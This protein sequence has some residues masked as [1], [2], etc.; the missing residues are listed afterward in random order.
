M[1]LKLASLLFGY[2]YELLKEQTMASRQ[3][4]STLA[5]LLLIPVF[6]WG[7]TGYFLSRNLMDSSF[8]VALA[9][10]ISMAGIIFLVDRSF[11]TASCNGTGKYLGW[12]RFGF[13]ILSAVLGAATLDMVIFEEDILNYQTKKSSQITKDKKDEYLKEHAH[14]LEPFR[15]ELDRQK[16]LERETHRAWM[17]EID[18]K[19]GPSGVGKRAA[20]KK[21]AWQ[22]AS[23]A[24]SEAT[25][26]L[27]SNTYELD[28]SAQDYGDAM[29]DLGKKTII[30]KFRDFHE[31]VFSDIYAGI[32][33]GLFFVM[34]LM[35]ELFLL[36][37]KTAARKTIFDQ[38]QELE[39]ELILKELESM[40]TMKQRMLFRNEAL[41]PGFQREVTRRASHN[42]RRA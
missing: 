5:L 21:L 27:D 17:D 7:I 39:E 25:T 18:G 10:S 9:V 14:M 34:M 26:K 1:T 19:M 12:F 6:I 33:W 31:F 22:T 4:L 3:K 24:L 29:A 38:M 32:G 30:G 40:R 20:E 23:A 16:I 42:V 13:A 35:L 15:A 2:K 8:S 41:D 28:S 11:V 37:Y 36:V